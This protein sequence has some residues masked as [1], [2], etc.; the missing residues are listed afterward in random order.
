MP[1]QHYI[2]AT[3]GHVDH[4]KS[5]LVKALTG[6]DPDRLPEEQARG[7][8]IDLGFAHLELE[9]PAGAPPGADRLSV[10]VVDVPGHEDFVKNMV[11]GVGSIDAALLVVAADDGWMPQTEEH[12]QILTYL[13]VTRGVV[14]LTKIDLAE[15]REDALTAAIR[16]HLSDSPLAGAPVVPTSVVTARGLDALR[17]ALAGVLAATP[18]PRDLGKPRLPVDRVFTLKGVGTVVTGTLT[19]GRIERGQMVAVCP[20]THTV[21]VRGLQSHQAEQEAAL[22]G[23]RT[24]L[25]LPDLGLRAGGDP[26]GLGRGDTITL[27]ALRETTDTVDVLLVRSPRLVG[28]PVPAARPLKDRTRVRVHSGSADLAATLFLHG[29]GEL[30]AG[31]RVLAQIRLEAPACLFGGDR[32]IVRD[33]SEQATLAGGVVLDPA[34]N[35]KHWQHRAQRTLLEARA[36]APDDVTVWVSSLLV[37]DGLAPR[38][39]LLD[40]SRFGVAEV[41]SA[42]AALEAAGRVVLAGGLAADRA[43]WQ[44]WLEGAQA[45]VDEAHRNHPEWPGLP[46]ADLRAWFSGQCALTPAFESLLTAL[47]AEG[48][49]QTGSAIRRRTHRPVLPQRL[50]AA[51]D[52]VRRLLGEKPLDPPS[53]KELAPDPA[54]R[55]AL[56]FLLESGEAVEVGPDLVLSASAYAAAVAAVKRELGQ[57]GRATV[58]DLRQALGCTRRIMV[59]LCEKLDR[60]G[61]TRRDGDFRQAGLSA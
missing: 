39:G 45:A 11:A 10:G 51:G 36:Q 20:G 44:G 17:D 24:A 59:P 12:L 16:A 29:G 2:V 31:G 8:T 25:N 3:A 53:R 41:E 55:E 23:Q 37:R 9:A 26:A 4:G 50:Q 61:I 6:T 48:F 30:A 43:R 7:I 40:R 38:A 54:T 28:R 60:A 19:G 21:R 56:R 22:P 13:G 33:W 34:G 1:A 18:P 14:A 49:L 42:L 27:P 58:S 47:L 52:W 32:F 5:A 46:L 15:G 57:R 35:R